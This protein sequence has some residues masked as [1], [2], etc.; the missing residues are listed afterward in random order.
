MFW[1]TYQ[2]LLEDQP[3]RSCSESDSDYQF[4][5]ERHLQAMWLEQRYFRGLTTHLGE[6]I[7][8][9]SPGIWN[10]EAGPDF[11]K[12]HLR[13]NGKDLYG[14][15][16]IHLS[17]NGWHQH[18]H[19]KDPRY[20]KVILHVSLWLPTRQAE[21]VTS[22]GTAIMRTYLDP[23]LTTPL[24]R[25]VRLIDLDLYPY[26]K[27]IGSGRC[28]QALFRHLPEDKTQALFSS[29]TYWRLEQKRSFLEARVEDPS[30]RLPA[31]IAMALGYKANTDTFLQLF[32]WL[33]QYA[34]RQFNDILA[35]ALGVTGFFEEPY[36]TRWQSSDLYLALRCRWI[37][38]EGG[39][40]F[41]LPISV[42][43]WR[44]LNHPVR[45]LVFL[46]HLVADSGRK[47][48]MNQLHRHWRVA[49]QGCHS[50]REASQLRLI[51]LSVLPSYE[52]AFWNYHFLFNSE[53]TA[54]LIPLMGQD[55]RHLILVNTLLPLL[56]EDILQRNNQEELA[57]FDRLYRSVRAPASGKQKYLVHRFFGETTKGTL[58]KQS[59]FEQGAFQIHRDF[60]VHYEA[61]CEGCPF[62]E[63]VR[64]VLRIKQ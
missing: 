52:D 3:T 33:Q 42:Q 17:D 22:S 37:A 53:T 8:V 36:H 47:T 32:L 5:R 35:L 62:I 57:V 15:V 18:H 10:A 51:L 9:V 48:L 34:D 24:K 21:I 59:V 31:G 50:A 4:I 45:R 12:A 6:P 26:K 38:F 44:P 61:S 40:T 11:C 60:C 49:W 25:I 39:N 2:Q 58:L 19:H 30:L 20:D 23:A 64:D 46:C 63:K 29:A 56:H 27:F 13:I 28:A 7:E 1:E 55:L 14:D 43:Q 16:E 41:R 54:Q